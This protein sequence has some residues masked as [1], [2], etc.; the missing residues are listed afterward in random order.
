MAIKPKQPTLTV[1]GIDT[2]LGQQIQEQREDFKQTSEAN[3][4]IRDGGL[5]IDPNS[6]VVD[7]PGLAQAHTEWR[8]YMSNFLENNTNRIINDTVPT[9]SVKNNK[10]VV[11]GTRSALDSPMTQS[12]K[13]ALKSLAGADLSSEDVQKAIEQVN[14]SLKNSVNDFLV[15]EVYGFEDSN[16]Y[17]NYLYAIQESK[18]P[19]SSKST[20]LISA[21]DKD[22]KVTTMTIKDWFD[23]WK[24][25]YSTDERADLFVNSASAKYGYDRIPYILMSK[26]GEQGGQDFAVLGFDSGEYLSLGL[27]N[28]VNEIIKLNH[29]LTQTVQSRLSG[30]ADSVDAMK[31]LGFDDTKSSEL[32]YGAKYVDED[33]FN[34]IKEK[35]FSRGPAIGGFNTLSDEEKAIIVLGT[36]VSGVGIEAGSHGEGGLERLLN[37]SSYDTYKSKISAI[38]EINDRNEKM[39]A[40]SDRIAK[41]MS[42]YGGS[43]LQFGSSMIGVMARQFEEAYAL[44]ALSGGRI[45]L[46]QLGENIGNTIADLYAGSGSILGTAAARSIAQFIGGIPEDMIQDFTD[47]ILSADPSMAEGIL[48][49]ENIASNLIYRLAFNA[50][51]KTPGRIIKNTLTLKQLSDAAKSAGYD[52]DA[53]DVK[54]SITEAYDAVKEGRKLVA[55]DDGNVMYYDS[56]GNLK[57]LDGVTV[58]NIE[59]LTNLKTS[60]IVD[61]A[62]KSLVDEWKT[63]DPVRSPDII[64]IR[65]YFDTG[66]WDYTLDS[67]KG[68]DFDPPKFLKQTVFD[69]ATGELGDFLNNKMTL[70]S[71]FLKGKNLLDDSLDPGTIK[72]INDN[73]KNINEVFN[74]NIKELSAGESYRNVINDITDFLGKFTDGYDDDMKKMISQGFVDKLTNFN[75]LWG[76]YLDGKVS[77]R[78]T[79]FKQFPSGV[80]NRINSMIYSASKAA[81]ENPDTINWNKLDKI[82]GGKY[83]D[84]NT[85]P[86]TLSRFIKDSLTPILFDI[87]NDF[88]TKA[89][90]LTANDFVDYLEAGIKDITALLDDKSV[91]PGIA[92]AALDNFNKQLSDLEYELYYSRNFTPLEE[93][94][95]DDIYSADKISV[96]LNEQKIALMD[97]AKNMSASEF[98]FGKL[99]A[100]KTQSLGS[101]SSDIDYYLETGAINPSLSSLSH[102][103]LDELFNFAKDIYD[104]VK[105]ISTD[106]FIKDGV[107]SDSAIEVRKKVI[108]WEATKKKFLIEHGLYKESADNLTQNDLLEIWTESQYRDMDSKKMLDI[109]AEFTDDGTGELHPEDLDNVGFGDYIHTAT[110]N[111][112]LNNIDTEGTFW[113]EVTGTFKKEK[114]YNWIMSEYKKGNPAI[115]IKENGDIN[116]AGRSMIE[117][118]ALQDK[119]LWA[120]SLIELKTMMASDAHALLPDMSRTLKEG[121]RLPADIEMQKVLKAIYIGDGE[122]QTPE[123]IESFVKSMVNIDS[124]D[125][126]ASEYTK[127]NFKKKLAEY[128]A[129]T[130]AKQSDAD[131]WTKLINYA[132]DNY[133]L[134]KVTLAFKQNAAAGRM[135]MA[136]FLETPF[137]VNR[138][139]KVWGPGR[140]VD[141]DG[142]GRLTDPT[143]DLATETTVSATFAVHSTFAFGPHD[144]GAI[145]LKVKPIDMLGNFGS[146]FANEKEIFIRKSIAYPAGRKMH[147]I[148]MDGVQTTYPGKILG[149]KN[150]RMYQVDESLVINAY[151]YGK[152]NR[153]FGELSYAFDKALTS[154]FREW[155]DKVRLLY[156]EN[157]IDENGYVDI[158]KLSGAPEQLVNAFKAINE[159]VYG[160]QIIDAILSN[161]P[162]TRKTVEHIIRDGFR[163][164]GL[165]DDHAF[166]KTLYSRLFNKPFVIDGDGVVG[167]E[168]G[169]VPSLDKEIAT[170]GGVHLNDPQA[171]RRVDVDDVFK[172]L[173]EKAQDNVDKGNIKLIDNPGITVDGNMVSV[174]ALID[175]APVDSRL[176]AIKNIASIK[177]DSIKMANKL[178]SEPNDA[179]DPINWD[180]T[181]A[182]VEFKTFADALANRPS[183]ANAH[184]YRKWMAAAVDAGMKEFTDWH[185][186]VFIANHPD[187]N[188]NQLVE[189]WDFVNFL[190][191]KGE[192][193]ADVD[194]DSII[195][196]TFVDSSG[197]E[198]SITK[199]VIDMYGEYDSFI[200]EQGARIAALNAKGISEDYNQLG[201][202]PHTDYNPMNQTAEELIH[203]ALWMKNE[204]KNSTDEYG[205]FTTS[206]LDNNFENRYRVWISNMAFDALGDVAT[207]GEKMK[208]LIAD[209]VFEKVGNGKMEDGS[210]PQ[211]AVAKAISGDKNLNEQASKTK[212]SKDFTK[213]HT[214]INN[215]I[216][217]KAIDK[218][219]EIDQEKVGYAKALHD[220]YGSIYGSNKA[221]VISQKN[222]FVSKIT[223]LYDF[224]KST[225]TTDG[226]LLD[227][228]GEMLINPAGFAN[229]II[230][231][232]RD[233]GNLKEL[234]V[235][236]LQQKS[237]RSARGAEYMY[238]K[239]LPDIQKHIRSDGKVNSAELAAVLTKHLRYEAWTGIKKWL[240]RA[241]YDQFNS[242]TQKTLNNLL[243]RHN[244][245]QQISNTPSV[246]KTINNAMNTIVGMRHRALF[247]INPKN[248]ILQLS[249]CIRLF[250]EFNLGDATKALKRLYS[251][252]EFRNTVAEWKQIVMPDGSRLENVEPMADAWHKTASFAKL[253]EDGTLDIKGTVKGGIQDADA[254]ALAPINAAE[255][256]KNTTLLAGIVQEMETKK[257]NGTLKESE[258]DFVMR[259]FQRIALAND[260]FGRLGYSDSTLART[261]LY[262][263][264]FSIRQLKMF[265]DNLID[266]WGSGGPAKAFGYLA[267]TL[268]WRM[269]LFM[270][271]AKLG[272]SAGQVLG[273]DPFDMLG[274]DYTGLDEEDE[275]E[276]DRQIKSGALSPLFI[277]G[278]TSMIQNYYFAMRQ[279][280]ERSNESTPLDEAEATVENREDWGLKM[281]DVDWFELLYSWMPGGGATRRTIQMTELLDKGAAF[282]QSGTQ[283]YSAPDDLGNIAAGYLFGRS[284]TANARAYY[285][286]PDPL[287]GL[288]DNGFAGF[289]QQMGR[290]NPFRNF[291]E[292]DPIDKDN[293]TDW[294]DGSDNDEQQWQSGYYYFRN[295]AKRIY[296][297]YNVQAGTFT[298]SNDVADLKSGYREEMAELGEKMNRFT[299]AYMNKHGNI[300]GNKMQQLLNV[301]ND[302]QTNLLMDDATRTSE[303]L[304]GLQRA[305]DRYTQAQLPAVTKQS[306]PTTS[307]PD[308]QYKTLMSPQFYSA[309]QGYYGAASEAAGIL[310]G[311]YE[312]KWKALRKEYSDKAFAKGTSFSDREKIQN[313]YINIVRQD[314]DG[315]IS[316]YGNNIL[317]NDEVDDIMTDVFAGM[318]PYSEYNVNKKGRRVSLPSNVEVDVSDWLQDK[319]SGFTKRIS[320]N[321][322]A[323]QT[324]TEI[325]RLQNSGRTSSAKALA[326]VLLQRVQENRQSV[327]RSELEYL[328]GLLK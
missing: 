216:D 189:S 311:L 21:R 186:N 149:D 270:V 83:V 57:R 315:I 167:Y 259:R 162:I 322:P 33:T 282:S 230:R 38:H 22:G 187:V 266:S 297:A 117:I 262:L 205:N 217:F 15:T 183:Y 249:E 328:Q 85:N 169:F 90:N 323:N 225:S 239:W 214:D 300:D 213:V 178:K 254:V 143:M 279:A 209:G 91:S 269:A 316:L 321:Q 314:L 55:D 154:N 223:G 87:T 163:Y 31:A 69:H 251:D 107:P 108:G 78:D 219:I 325:K 195:G 221:N 129:A 250:S 312:N 184:H 212:S 122:H 175:S 98:V 273:Y 145:A 281:P 198:I 84:I 248:A 194:I 327:T 28:T 56:D 35:L 126:N 25:N 220:N 236:L 26:G 148:Y 211:E 75:R 5:T 181:G 155:F 160:K 52:I 173:K 208:E 207:F 253:N 8:N 319:Y 42:V 139:E 172:A 92:S 307:S 67:V 318:V 302:A 118:K 280:Y 237:G 238:S 104:E 231:Q 190:V 81:I 292:F 152:I 125:S 95:L 179:P 265:G 77:P 185:Q 193:I 97:E 247:Y 99:A 264:N 294:F 82:T 147:T 261:A 76:E 192:S 243:Y 301:L 286:T 30:V 159:T 227:H 165:V 63:K 263:Q 113:Y 49:P 51:V 116:T 210:T 153:A 4:A 23:Y 285:Q 242:A 94:V 16:D 13:N 79:I 60:E 50:I 71:E 138:V 37:E 18:K 54:R 218:Q 283:M 3:K 132:V 156:L 288:V 168:K 197:K 93:T 102:D 157:A 222:V 110:K 34:K 10:I 241:N 229:N 112:M 9:F 70:S 166:M 305:R 7:V 256:M 101:L 43:A 96:A 17:N 278:I 255:D 174:A 127:S 245:I 45:D 65:N 115:Y 296:D 182:P 29:G 86:N 272:Y 114:Y 66:E 191:H 80:D 290:T 72:S 19:N 199:D 326:R 271:M 277:G 89:Y 134:S 133:A 140:L 313:E 287:Q 164:G 131:Y 36:R 14:E 233:G 48:T 234:V 128:E 303:S 6:Q 171:K 32:I 150:A 111:Y 135:S 200:K 68:Y 40:I 289:A 39:G 88:S 62:V 12:A 61:N 228:G 203:G 201:Y 202:L 196:K 309:V 176:A 204:L 74:A 144:P 46:N 206:K 137:L 260:E 119:K 11:S 161:N 232:Y 295:E 275:T 299:Q 246:M 276:L 151:D 291:R 146:F 320:Y 124:P 103:A 136:E 158:K 177:S 106:S 224:M 226:N 27:Y 244:M 324:I 130:G 123:S 100:E 235:D 73:I 306:G 58:F 304:A 64:N 188:M 308:A 215:K 240:A 170:N 310:S 274:E 284:N 41:N 59:P 317:A 298:S 2:N 121:L 1:P 258:Y 252:S 47:S 109:M 53:D 120:A 20:A 24:K 293:Y 141:V 180:D 257:A 142:S 268:G 105:S 267:K 44:K